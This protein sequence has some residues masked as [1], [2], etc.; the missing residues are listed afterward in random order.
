MRQK[1]IDIFLDALKCFHFEQRRKLSYFQI[2]IIISS[3]QSY[4][5]KK[6]PKTTDVFLVP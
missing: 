2:V 1:T 4:L 5:N 3:G 6:T